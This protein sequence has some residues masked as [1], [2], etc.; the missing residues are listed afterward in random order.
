ME[1]ISGYL[2]DP[3]LRQSFN[4]LA[5]ET[6]SLDFEPWYQGGMLPHGRYIPHSL[7]Q[8]GEVIANCSAN[9]FDLIVEGREVPAVQLGTVMTAKE[10]RGRGLMSGLMERVLAH[11]K[12]RELIYL[13]A[14]DQVL[15]FYPKFGFRRIPQTAYSLDVSALKRQDASPHQ[16]NTDDPQDR[17]LLLRLCERRVPVSQTLGVHRDCWPLRA[18][19]SLVPRR[20]WRL[21][22]RIIVM[23]RTDDTLYIDDIL[24]EQPFALDELL[25][26]L[27]PPGCRRLRLGFCPDQSALPF[28]REP[29]WEDDNALFV[30]GDALPKEFC[31]PETSHT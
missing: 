22:E 17:A 18:A 2:N 14:N 11:Y 28:S 8:D 6:F 23:E 29:L 9:L 1:L 31:F 12:D 30:R 13:F 7:V 25:P 10:H 20:L 4:R 21:E 26:S 15:G 27:V 24:S 16:L 5:I 3:A 19:C